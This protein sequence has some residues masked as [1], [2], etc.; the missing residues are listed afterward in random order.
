[1]EEDLRPDDILMRLG[2]ADCPED[3]QM[4]VNR[5]LDM[6]IPLLSPMR[7]RSYV[8]DSNTCGDVI[9]GPCFSNCGQ[10]ICSP[11]FRGV[12]IFDFAGGLRH[13][14]GMNEPKIIGL[15]LARALLNTHSGGVLVCRY[16]PYLPLL[17]DGG[18]EGS[19]NFYAPQ[20]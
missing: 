1:M 4:P 17:A 3:D 19:V 15:R 20:L 11:Y 10:F 13:L 5:S 7:I 16:H 14:G 18:S 8:S 12:R 6:V 9:K 2:F